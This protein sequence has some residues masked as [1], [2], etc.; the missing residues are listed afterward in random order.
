MSKEIEEKLDKIP[1]INWLVRLLKNIR[2]PGFEGLSIYDLIEMYIRGIVEGAL[3]TRASSIAFSLFLA[4]FPLLIF[5]LTLVPFLIS[6]FSL[7]NTGFDE[8]FPAFL[9]SFLPTATGDYFEQIYQQ[10]KD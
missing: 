2:L 6:I 7:H 4:L 1:V 5:M 3:S 9:E 8:N 10:I